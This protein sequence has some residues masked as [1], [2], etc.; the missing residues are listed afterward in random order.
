MAV[1]P[2]VGLLGGSFDPVHRAHIAL[3]RAACDALGLE[4]VEL[5]PAARPWQRGRLG[6]AAE[7]RL[8][9]LELACSGDPR[10]RV[11][12]IELQ[13]AGNTYTI[14]T[15]AALPPTA[16][17]TWILGSDQ[18]ANFCTWHRWHDL[19]QY[20]RLAVAERPGTP[21]TPPAELAQALTPGGLVRIPF[22]P[23]PVSAT[24]IRQDLAAGRPVDT[25]LDPRVLDYIRAH[26]LYLDPETS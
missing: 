11:N 13:R 10:L 22:T 3:A 26:R 12:P 9:M 17:Y 7:H 8:R 14:D 1:T 21:A 6:A 19:L 16:R 5:L 25:M 15:L 20:V 4:H 2:Q 24:A 23:Q 18:L